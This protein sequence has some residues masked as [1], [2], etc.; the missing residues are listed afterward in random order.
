MFKE[1]I[2]DAKENVE[3]IYF[4]LGLE[5]VNDDNIEWNEAYLLLDPNAHYLDIERIDKRHVREA[6]NYLIYEKYPRDL[7]YRRD[8][9]MPTGEVE[10][11]IKKVKNFINKWLTNPKYR[12]A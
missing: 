9:K 4:E 7:Q 2:D 5:E 6:C 1:L 10:E 11:N 8:E 12:K 3:D